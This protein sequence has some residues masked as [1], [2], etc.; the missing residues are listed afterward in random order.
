MTESTPHADACETLSR[1]PE[2]TERIGA[3]LAA[4]LRPGDVVG[5]Y[6]DLG[7]GKTCLVRGL[8]R[9][10]HCTGEATSPT[11]TLI[12]EYPGRP[13]LYHFDLYRLR[14][15]AELEDLDCDDYFFGRGVTVVEWAEKAGPLLPRRRWEVRLEI[16]DEDLR[17][18]RIQPPPGESTPCSC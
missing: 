11:F 15:S 1:A 18:I 2:E 4:R 10:L 14:G 6:G 3:E 9:G 13:P 7:A 8:A 5:L 17:R 16:L 12:H